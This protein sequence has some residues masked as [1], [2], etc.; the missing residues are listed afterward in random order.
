ME[1][2]RQH[3]LTMIQNNGAA[4]QLERVIKDDGAVGWSQN[5][6]ANAAGKS[7]RRYGKSLPDHRCK[8]ADYRMVRCHESM[9]VTGE[10]KMPSHWRSSVAGIVKG[11]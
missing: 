6:R 4:A 10:V 1:V 9:V 2:G 3:P 11:G 7:R 8:I 5:G